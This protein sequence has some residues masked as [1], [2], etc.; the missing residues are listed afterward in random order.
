QG[1]QDQDDVPISPAKPPIGTD[2]PAFPAAVRPII[3]LRATGRT[4]HHSRRRA[5]L[6]VSLFSGRIL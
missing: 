2:P 1:N 4:F 3:N 6:I 5:I